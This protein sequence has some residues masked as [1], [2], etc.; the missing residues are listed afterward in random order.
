MYKTKTA[1]VPSDLQALEEKRIIN[2]QLVAIAEK[3]YSTAEAMD[4]KGKKQI[5]VLAKNNELLNLVL[6]FLYKVRM[7]NFFLLFEDLKKANS[8]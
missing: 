8:T 4:E 5:K 3:A 2:D 7:Q 6:V 1:Q